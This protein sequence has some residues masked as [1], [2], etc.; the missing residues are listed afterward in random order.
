MSLAVASAPGDASKYRLLSKDETNSEVP[1]PSSGPRLQYTM[2]REKLKAARVGPVAGP[3]LYLHQRNAIQRN[4]NITAQKGGTDQHDV[5]SIVTHNTRDIAVRA[6]R[7]RETSNPVQ[8]IKSTLPNSTYTA[9]PVLPAQV[10][11]ESAEP[12]VKRFSFTNARTLLLIVQLS[13]KF[14]R[15][16]A[17]L[18]S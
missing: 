9:A 5:A 15:K 1:P 11:P 8:S 4:H 12:G 6:G 16:P 2:L 17:H 13:P 10:W 7:E 18:T 3:A 14:W